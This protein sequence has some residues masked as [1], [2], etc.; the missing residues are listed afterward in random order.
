MPS[1]IPFKYKGIHLC[2]DDQ[3][4]LCNSDTG[5][6]EM[7]K[8]DNFQGKNMNLN[9]RD[10]SIKIE[11]YDVD[12]GWL[13][14]KININNDELDMRTSYCLGDGFQAL[15]ERIYYLHPDAYDN[16][17]S[18]EIVET[19]EIATVLDETRIAVEV[20][21]KTN[22]YWDEEGSFIDWEIEHE[23]TLDRE[24]DLYLKIIITRNDEK[25]KFEYTVS[26]KEFCYALSKACTEL[27]KKYGIN[28]F[29][30]SYW[31]GDIN[32]R[33]LLFIKA[34]ALDADEM[35]KVECKDK[36]EMKSNIENELKLL[37]FDM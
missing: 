14:L 31:D 10:C 15:L 9:K 8:V 36:N 17:F 35:I 22:F 7:L 33:H 37:L 34:I 29:H 21:Y 11:F 30:Q 32:L 24:F 12:A 25:Q 19:E 5:P 18:G 1:K 3:S 13:H 20:P 2:K 27:L 4:I 26:Y 16:D 6:T 23:P 28:G